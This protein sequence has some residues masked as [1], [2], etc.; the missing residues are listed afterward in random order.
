VCV[1]L[2][3]VCHELKTTIGL[4][5]GNHAPIVRDS[6]RS[7]TQRLTRKLPSFTTTG[8]VTVGTRTGSCVTSG[9]GNKE[10]ERYYY[11]HIYI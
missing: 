8:A 3:T 5:A 10:T 11:T 7:R 6:E 1:S 4:F 9:D 2:Y